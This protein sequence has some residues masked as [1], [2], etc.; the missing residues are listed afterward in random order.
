MK[1]PVHKTAPLQVRWRS[2][3][4]SASQEIKR[5]KEE[6]FQSML[7]KLLIFFLQTMPNISIKAML[8]ILEFDK[9]NFTFWN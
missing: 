6:N 5:N 9:S 7:E 1:V 8:Y 2:S 3:L 4:K